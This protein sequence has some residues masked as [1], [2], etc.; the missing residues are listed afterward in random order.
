L[1]QLGTISRTFQKKCPKYPKYADFDHFRT[2][3]RLSAPLEGPGVFSRAKTFW[4]PLPNGLRK[5]K[6][7]Q[8]A[9]VGSDPIP[10]LSAHGALLRRARRHCTA[11]HCTALHCTALHCTALH[12]TACLPRARHHLAPRE[13]GRGAACLQPGLY[14][15]PLHCTALHYTALHCT[16]LH[17]TALH[18]TARD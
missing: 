1:G 14:R 6:S 5:P 11:L 18:C 15:S 17:C 8:T 2:F 10:P 3:V 16:A 13:K 12:C 9:N 7:H 4:I